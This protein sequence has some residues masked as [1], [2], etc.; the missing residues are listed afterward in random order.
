MGRAYYGITKSINNVEWQFELHNSASALNHELLIAADP[1][2]ERSG[3][4]DILF[5]NP[6]RSSRCTVGFVMRD[7]NDYGNFVNIGFAEEQEWTL[8]VYKGGVLWWVGMV[9][10]DQMQFDREPRE[11]GYAII[12]ITAADGLERLKG[13]DVLP[14]W[15]TSGRA[16]A[17]YLV[18]Q[19]VN[20]CGLSDEFTGTY[21]DEYLKVSSEMSNANTHASYGDW[22]MKLRDISFIKNDDVF[23]DSSEIEW[24]DCHAALSQILTAFGCRIHHEK[25]AY[26]V[27][28]VNGYNDTAF[29]YDTYNGG[30]LN[31]SYGSTYSH[32]LT[33]SDSGN[34]R[35]KWAT[36]PVLSYQPPVRA[37]VAQFDRINGAIATKTTYNTTKVEATHDDIVATASPPGR[38]LRFT[39]NV[40]F[41][42]EKY[43]GGT[44]YYKYFLATRIYAETGGGTKYQAHNG[45]W[46]TVVTPADWATWVEV[47]PNTAIK[48]RFTHT[49][50]LVAPPTGATTVYARVYVR[51]VSEA[52]QRYRGV[53]ASASTTDA[54][55][56]GS[57]TI[58]QA[59]NQ[60]TPWEYVQKYE[61]ET[62]IDTPRDTN[63]ELKELQC[64]YYNGKK[65]DVGSVLVRTGAATWGEAGD[66]S[67]GWTAT[68]G[69]IPEILAD[70]FAGIYS[71]F[72]PSIR[73][74]LHDA[75]NYTAIDSLYF[76]SYTWVLNGVRQNLMNDTWEGEW[77]GVAINYTNTTNNGEG[78]R[79]LQ[80]RELIEERFDNIETEGSRMRD[81]LGALP[82]QLPSDI[83]NNADN[84]PTSDPGED[85]YYGVE[86]FYDYDATAPDFR[87]ALTAKQSNLYEI[88]STSSATYNLTKTFG[89]WILK[90][91]TSS[92][93]I[94]VNLPAASGNKAKFHIMKTTGD[95]NAATIYG[96]G[97]ETISGAATVPIATQWQVYTIISDN[98]NWLII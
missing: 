48:N 32:R 28:H 51:K 20:M 69:D 80:D 92:N 39:F 29:G 81:V 61:F 35:P 22:D 34:S 77:L 58:S 65:Y 47:T 90:C 66:W 21:F 27:V 56:V 72:V 38:A 18:A 9:L 89:E 75:G 63:S 93:A 10:A 86:L 98:S 13:F 19:I 84:A 85:R 57:A 78:Q 71:D 76:D 88:L 41:T 62:E 8:R 55:F 91:D 44:R 95:G 94:M 83:V 2:I 7:E 42:T 50:E 5:D 25:G 11:T 82:E 6:I 1:I 52:F 37:V 40:E 67:A 53:W 46:S 30:G 60:T 79:V 45:S 33:V 64:N 16:E 96:N 24:M 68:T 31:D 15:F 23:K 97:A 3:E 14:G 49:V 26:W 43:A 12:T 70:A 59:Y 36:Y 73:G 74:T 4:G 17:A 87:W 54:D